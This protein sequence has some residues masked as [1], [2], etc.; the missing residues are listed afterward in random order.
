MNVFQS[1]L[2]RR[3]LPCPK[4][5]LAMRLQIPVDSYY[6][7]FSSLHTTIFISLLIIWQLSRIWGAIYIIYLIFWSLLPQFC[8]IV[9]MVLSDFAFAAMNRHQK[10]VTIATSRFLLSTDFIELY[11]QSIYSTLYTM[12]QIFDNAIRKQI[13]H[14]FFH[15][16]FLLFFK[17]FYCHL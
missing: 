7:S 17:R 4:K 12:L 11:L 8:D 9:F 6:K 1:A 5:F 15:F 14:C 16:Y 2:I 10:W 3:I 13:F